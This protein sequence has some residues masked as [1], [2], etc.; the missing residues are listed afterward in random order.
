MATFQALN[1]Y[2]WLVVTVFH[3]AGLFIYF[4]HLEYIILLEQFLGFNAGYLVNILVTYLVAKIS[5]PQ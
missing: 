3:K 2:L 1:M 4:A 5:S